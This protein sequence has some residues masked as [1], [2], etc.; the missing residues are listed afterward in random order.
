MS[1]ASDEPELFQVG[2]RAGEV[3]GVAV[4]DENDARAWQGANLGDELLRPGH[5]AG[6]GLGHPLLP[7]LLAVALAAGLEPALVAGVIQYRL[8]QIHHDS[9]WARFLFIRRPDL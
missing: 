6:V 4:A 1:L 2:L 7:R 9:P 3:A 5:E 8:I